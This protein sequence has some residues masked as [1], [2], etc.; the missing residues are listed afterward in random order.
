MSPLWHCVFGA[1]AAEAAPAPAATQ[2][3]ADVTAIASSHFARRMPTSVF[4]CH[5]GADRS[6]D[7][8]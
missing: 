4:A 3:A 2:I 5:A 7:G 1:P 8:D 6:P